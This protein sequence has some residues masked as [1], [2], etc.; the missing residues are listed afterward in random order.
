MNSVRIIWE[1][2]RYFSTPERMKGLLSKISNQIIKRCRAKINKEDML[3][4][5]VE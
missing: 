5:D 1:L 3:D 2:S 4:G